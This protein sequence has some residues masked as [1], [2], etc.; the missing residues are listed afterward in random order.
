MRRSLVLV[1]VLAVALPAAGQEAFSIQFFPVVARGPG[2]AGTQWV[3]DLTIHNPLDEAVTVGMQFFVAN[4][5]NLFNPLFPDSV[6][7]PPG[8]TVIMEDVLQTTFGYTDAVKGGMVLVSDP[9]YLI[10]NPSNTKVIAVTRTYNVGSP[11]GTFGQTVP[12]MVS[13][14]NVGWDSSFITGAR[15]DADFRSNLGISSTSV[16]STLRVHYAIK[17]AGG[18]VLADGSKVI[19]VASMNQWSFEQLGVGTVDGP[20]TVELWLDPA[21][22]SADPCADEPAPPGFFAYV[23]KVDNGTGDAEFLVSAPLMPFLC[24]FEE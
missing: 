10:G 7:I 3:T 20:L 15:N 22:A 14:L 24:A 5:D 6:T 23:S 12:S 11:E 21:N 13:T 2:L 8:E 4:E 17:D 1:A 9:D 19:R 18:A 16:M